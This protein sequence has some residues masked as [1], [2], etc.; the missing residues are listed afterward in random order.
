MGYSRRPTVKG[1]DLKK[2][3]EEEIPLYQ[4]FSTFLFQRNIFKGK[5]INLL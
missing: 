1:S 5:L 4:I 3:K 2:R